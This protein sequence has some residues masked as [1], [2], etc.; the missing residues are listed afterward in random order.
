[1]KGKK[2]NNRGFIMS[3]IFLTINTIHIKLDLVKNINN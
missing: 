3:K 1:M 2:I